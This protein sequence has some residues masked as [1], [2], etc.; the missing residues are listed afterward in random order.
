M[1]ARAAARTIDS[2]LLHHRPVDRRAS[3]RRKRPHPSS[4]QP[5]PIIPTA[6]SLVGFS[7][8]RLL[9]QMSL[10]LRVFLFGNRRPGWPWFRHE[11]T[12]DQSIPSDQPP[13]DGDDATSKT[14]QHT[15]ARTLRGGATGHMRLGQ[16]L[17]TADG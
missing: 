8:S 11:T 12:Q 5:P 14:T 2:N 16:G 13:D 10:G 3:G 17:Q 1:Y 4:P 15:W 6:L 7:S 9:S